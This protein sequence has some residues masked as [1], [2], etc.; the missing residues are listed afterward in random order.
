MRASQYLFFTLKEIPNS[1][2]IISHQLMLKSGMIRKLSSGLYIWLPTGIKILNKI[3]KIIQNEMEKINACEILTPIIQPEKLWENSGRLNIYGQELLKFY[4]R[5]NQKF[6]LGPTNEEVITK[7]IGDEIYSYTELPLII[8]QIQTKFR[9]EIRPR[10]GVIRSREFIMKDAYSFHSNSKCL[11]K[12]YNI[13]HQSY[14]NILNQ[15][16][17]KFRVVSG[18]SKSM[19]GNISHEFQ[20]LSENGEDEIVFSKNTSYASNINTAESIESV[21]FTKEKKPNIHNSNIKSKKSI[22]NINE[23]KKPIKNLIKTILIRTKIK[24]NSSIAALL[25]REE[26]QLNLFKIEEID[27]VEKPLSFINEE[28][29]VQLMGVESK[30]L[31]PFG[32]NIPI[33]ADVS[34]YYMKNFTIGANINGN[35]FVNVNWN[36]DIPIPTIKDIRKIT[37]R[38]TSPDGSTCLEIKKS[39]EI[40]HIFQL[41][42][43]YSKKMNIMIQEKNNKKRN[44]HMGCYGIG[45]TRMI[46]AIIEQNYDQNGIIWPNSISPFEVVILPLGFNRY[47][48]IKTIAENLYKKFKKEKIDVMLYDRNERPGVMFNQIDLIG[49]PHQIIISPRHVQKDNVEY[50]A[51][52]NKKSIF[53]NIKDIYFFLRK[54]I[55]LNI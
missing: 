5:R 35:F 23:F 10:F 13:F 18:D 19:G 14:I 42:T 52:R 33:F 27:I 48:H 28:E 45:I 24:N 55:D 6:I 54:K 32:L 26:H 9:D 49:I 34:V 39:I 22:K 12:T 46:A 4:D 44:V 51:R 8:Y 37:K 25:I 15:V 16:N 38:D 1:A 20:A 3:K 47:I 36:V 7:F 21:N 31:G 40:G 53:I 11:E 30:F 17:L 29:I 43:E 2:K 50:R 41:G